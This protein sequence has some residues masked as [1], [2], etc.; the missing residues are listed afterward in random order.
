MNAVASALSRFG[1]GGSSRVS[2]DW[3]HTA[4]GWGGGL[5][6]QS[7][8]DFLNYYKKDAFTIAYGQMDPLTC[9]TLAYSNPWITAVVNAITRPIASSKPSAAPSSEGVDVDPV[10][11]D[12]IEGLISRPNE[13]MDFGSFMGAVMRDL[14]ITGNAFIEVAYNNFGVPGNLY[15]HPPYVI[16]VDDDGY[17]HRNGYRFKEG[18]LVHIRLP[19]PFDPYWGLSPLVS[20]VA[21]LMLDMNILMNNLKYFSN[22]Q[23]KGI[24]S[25]DKSID[26]MSAEKEVE[27]IQ[28]TIKNMRE[29]GDE[30]HLVAFGVT[31]QSLASTNKDMMT[32][33]VEK[34]IR[35][36]ILAVYGVPPSKVCLTETSTMSAGGGEAHAETMNETLTYW[37]SA[38]FIDPINSTITRW[39]GLKTVKL[40]LRGL[41]HKDELAM[42]R[43]HREWIRSSFATINEVRDAEGLPPIDSPVA[44]EPLLPLNVA[45]MSL[46][47]GGHPKYGDD[48][49]GGPDD[50]ETDRE[51][52]AY[53]EDDGHVDEF[54][55]ILM[56]EG[57]IR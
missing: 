4:F 3:P 24:L 25:I 14:L 6:F 54:M 7:L 18:E 51:S 52:N 37:A 50:A 56:R 13:G 8:Q 23:L 39:A 48:A 44:N 11:E 33:E 53:D 1:R 36:K 20:L 49:P 42:A 10:E 55:R 12:Y 35:D 2:D 26:Y 31:F 27:R 15:H 46:F 19:N 45:P 30:G 17:V 32:P 41:T 38:G 34:S 16:K 9:Y 22:S 28:Q 29:T 47:E 5:R 57:L 43:V 40:S 21:S